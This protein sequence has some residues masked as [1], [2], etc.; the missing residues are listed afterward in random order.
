MLEKNP[1][2]PRVPASDTT[3][4]ELVLTPLITT[5]FFKV[6]FVIAVVPVEP[7]NT[8][9]GLVTLVFVIVKLRSMPVPPMDPSTVTRL[10]PFIRINA[11]LNDPVIARPPP[12][13]HILTVNM[14]PHHR[15]EKTYTTYQ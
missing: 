2:L 12:L 13:R 6:S 3:T 8:T 7:S 5:Q 14:L 9:L 15:S 10:D 11:P 4:A 1:A